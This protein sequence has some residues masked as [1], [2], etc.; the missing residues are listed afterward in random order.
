[1]DTSNYPDEAWQRLGRAVKRRR[2]E[3]DMTQP[4]LATTGGPSTSIISKIERAAQQGY[5][6]RVYA[7]LDRGLG[8]APGGALGILDGKEPQVAGGP[9]EEDS[10]A[11]RR[12]SA[13]FEQQLLREPSVLHEPGSGADLVFPSQ[14]IELDPDLRP[15]GPN[16]LPD[17]ID[18]DSLEAWERQI[19]CAGA[20]TIEEREDVIEFVRGRRRVRAAREAGSPGRHES[21]TG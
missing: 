11:F 21:D 19:W 8:W 6:D 16:D 5:E 4:Q 1:M 15:H 18:W 2:L 10:S 3:L 20:L 13:L 9:R 17:Y 14:T 7:A 12:L